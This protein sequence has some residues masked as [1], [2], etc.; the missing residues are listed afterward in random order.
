MNTHTTPSLQ[1]PSAT[2]HYLGLVIFAALSAVVGGLWLLGFLPGAAGG[3]T[4][5][6][7]LVSQALAAGILVYAV[8]EHFLLGKLQQDAADYAARQENCWSSALAA[9]CFAKHALPL[10]R[11]PDQVTEAVESGR[12]DLQAQLIE[13]LCYFSGAGLFLLPLLGLALT[14]EPL[15]AD[16]PAPSPFKLSGPLFI[17]IVEAFVL[18]AFI[19]R[20]LTTWLHWLNSWQAN[21]VQ[22]EQPTPPEP[23]PLQVEVKKKFVRPVGDAQPE[24]VAQAE[25]VG[26]AEGAAPRPE[27]A[28]ATPLAP[29]PVRRGI[30]RVNKDGE[31]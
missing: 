4:H 30:F 24:A 13:R 21:V 20:N 2:W 6:A 25:I 9:R 1:L 16:Q 18:G 7:F 28:A 22:R 15:E 31:T 8:Q 11:S 19:I 12:Q 3:L 27:P 14:F 5:P 10:E 26:Q 23:L 29:A 17:T